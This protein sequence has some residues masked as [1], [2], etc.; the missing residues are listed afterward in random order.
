MH[1]TGQ[2]EQFIKDFRNITID[3]AI[4]LEGLWMASQGEVDGYKSSKIMATLKF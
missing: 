2:S 3:G 4:R 1:S